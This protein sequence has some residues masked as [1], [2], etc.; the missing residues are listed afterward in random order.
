MW[1]EPCAVPADIDPG[2]VL[3]GRGKEDSVTLEERLGWHKER[4]CGLWPRRARRPSL[5]LG[6]FLFY[7]VTHFLF[8]FFLFFLPSF[9]LI[10]CLL[11]YGK[12]QYFF[13]IWMPK[14]SL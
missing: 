9:F 7:L 13:T 6:G 12:N 3:A 14:N 4:R 1:K 11:C 5:R 2:N 8:F 10:L